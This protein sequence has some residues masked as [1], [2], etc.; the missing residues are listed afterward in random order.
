MKFRS[1]EGRS[2]EK[3]V[4]VSR[5]RSSDLNREREFVSDQIRIELK[6]YCKLL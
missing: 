5:S 2:Q 1:V 3:T 6:I 4:Q